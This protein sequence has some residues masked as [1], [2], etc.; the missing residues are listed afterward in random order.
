[1]V[2]FK[3]YTCP[4]SQLKYLIVGTEGSTVETK[5]LVQDS[6]VGRYVD[7]WPQL[8]NTLHMRSWTFKYDHKSNK[9]S[10]AWYLEKPNPQRTN[11][12][13]T[14]SNLDRRMILEKL[15][16]GDNIVLEGFDDKRERFLP[17]TCE[18]MFAAFHHL[19]EENNGNMRV[20][21]N[22]WIQFWC[23]K[24]LKY[25]LAPP[26]KEKKS[27]RLSST[28]NPTGEIPTEINTRSSTQEMVFSKLGA[29]HQ[30]YETYLTA[31]LSCWLCAFVFSFEEGNFIRP[32]TFKIASLMV[33][34]KR[35]SLAVPV[36]ANIY[37]GLNKISYSSQLDH[38]RVCF[39]IHYV[40]GWLAYYLKTH[41]PL[42]SGP[43]LPRMVV[44]SGEGAAKYFDKDEARKRVHQGENIVWNATLLSRPHPTYYIDDGKAPELELAYFMSLRFNYLPLRRGGSFVIESYSPHRFSHQFGFHQDIPGYLENAIRAES[45]DEGLRYWRIC[46]A[47][48]TMS[49]ATFLPVI[50]SA[51]K[52]YTTQ[53]SSWWERS[54]GMVLE[55]NLDVMVEKARSEFVTLLEDKSQDIEK[56]LSKVKTSLAPQHQ[57]KKHNSSNVSKKEVVHTSTDK[58]KCPQFLFSSKRALQETSKTSKDRCW[59]RQRVE[60]SGA[61]V[62][63]LRVVEVRSVDSPSRTMTIQSDKVNAAGH[64]LGSPH[65]RPQLS[66]ESTAISRPKAKSI[67]NIKQERKTTSTSRGQTLKG[68]TPNSNELSRVLPKSNGAMSVFEGKCVVFNHKRKYILD[69]ICEIFKEISEMNLLDLSPLKILHLEL[70]KVEEGEKAKHVSSNKKSLKKVKRKLATLQGKREGLEAVLEAAKKNVEEIQAKILATEDEISSYENMS[71]LT[72]E[73]SIRL[74]QKRE[75]LEAT[76]QDLTNYKLRLD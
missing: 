28:H 7:P 43:S 27:R 63:N 24:D 21:F 50:T 38:I 75:C 30:K 29:K 60:P 58:E 74:E 59:K 62:V 13:S 8:R 31:F 68:L 18:C 19:K 34:G 46:I 9:A 65:E 53:Y 33:S 71:L 16:W 26:R 76:R 52:L 35:V 41:Y 47:R 3:D 51:K 44:Y 40:Y 10:K 12:A 15:R 32:E 25:E 54:Y 2:F 67:S 48:A 17:R 64:L 73:D 37:H 6:F 11:I 20:S 14:L 1:M 49:K 72:L 45:L 70:F 5:F 4:S 22:E 42:T 39:P 61:E 57:S 66:D 55:D 56:T 36:L 23:K 69:D